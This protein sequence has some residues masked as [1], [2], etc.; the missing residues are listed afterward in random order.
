MMKHYTL[1]DEARLIDEVEEQG[2]TF[3][4]ET[5][6]VTEIDDLHMKGVGPQLSSGCEEDALF[7]IPY[8]P[9]ATVTV[10]QPLMEPDPDPDAPSDRKRAYRDEKGFVVYESVEHKV[11]GEGHGVLHTLRVCANDDLM[12]HWPRFQHRMKDP[13]PL[14]G[15][16]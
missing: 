11:P 3:L 12:R 4:Q 15:N 6:M 7:E 13:D 5:C 9:A 14:T 8:D 1:G 10:N 2:G 16:R